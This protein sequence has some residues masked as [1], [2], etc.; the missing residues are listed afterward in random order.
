M[1]PAP[2]Y[3]EQ[4]APTM[5]DTPMTTAETQFETDRLILRSW[6][7]TDL[8]NFTRL[9]ASPLSMQDYRGPIDAEA[10]R[11][12]FNDYRAQ[13]QRH[14]FIRWH[15][16]D[17]SGAFLGYV[18]L[19][20]NGDDHPLGPNNDIGWRLLPEAWGKGYATEAARATL[21]HAFETY[22]LSEILAYT[23]AENL[24]SQAVISRLP[25]RRDPTRDFTVDDPVAGIWHGLTW[26]ITRDDQAAGGIE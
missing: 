21:A 4:Y 19:Y 10:S 8:T 16:A 25:M 5:L 14:G 18:G 17:K 12:K 2:F 3:R 13:Y 23:Q 26:A 1:P 24:A 11:L 9:H 15:V 20:P 22:G 7:A 6:R